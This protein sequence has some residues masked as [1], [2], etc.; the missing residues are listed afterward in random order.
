MIS[1]Q[2]AHSLAIWLAE[3]QPQVF[4]AVLRTAMGESKPQL[5][6]LTD[7]LSSIGTSVGNAVNA[8][9]RY[10]A[11]DEGMKTLSSIGQVYLASQAQ[12]DALKLQLAQA[13]AGNQLYPIQSV[14]QNPYSAIP[15]I[16]GQTLTPTLTQQLYPTNNAKW[17]PWA[18]GGVLLV[19]G[20]IVFI[21]RK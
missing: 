9:G 16:N 7:W 14:G 5:N 8:A 4:E 1:R 6:G 12:K 2:S 19:V 15:T 3:Q 18:I 17:I 10:L 11:S 21:P 20:L 13:Q